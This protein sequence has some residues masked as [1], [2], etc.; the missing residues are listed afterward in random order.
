[1]EKGCI[2]DRLS[3]KGFETVGSGLYMMKHAGL[4]DGRGLILGPNSPFKNIPNLGM[5]L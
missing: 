2:L 3:G 5:I 1:M 4:Y